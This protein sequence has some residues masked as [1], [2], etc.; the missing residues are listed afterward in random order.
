MPL[1]DLDPVRECFIWHK[2]HSRISFKSYTL[3][4]ETSKVR[5]IQHS[6]LIWRQS[7]PQALSCFSSH[8]HTLLVVASHCIRRIPCFR[9]HL[10]QWVNHHS[11]FFVRVSQILASCYLLISSASN[12]FQNRL[13]LLT[14]VSHPLTDAIATRWPVFLRLWLRLVVCSWWCFLW[15]NFLG[16]GPAEQHFDWR[17]AA[18]HNDGCGWVHI[19]LSCFTGICCISCE[20]LPSR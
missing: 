3:I 2:D 10:T 1:S 11:L 14:N 9:G 15:F 5:N 6:C 20:C 4:V 12:A 7:T 16:C 18:P 19:I 13:H 8:T 17:D